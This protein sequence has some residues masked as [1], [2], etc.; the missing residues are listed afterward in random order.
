M[1]ISSEQS[2]ARCGF[3]LH[4]PSAFISSK[5]SCMPG[6]QEHTYYDTEFNFSG[7]KFSWVPHSSTQPTCSERLLHLIQRLPVPAVSHAERGGCCPTSFL[8]AQVS[9]GED[10]FFFPPK[11]F[12]QPAIWSH[13]PQPSSALG[14]RSRGSQRSELDLWIQGFI[15]PTRKDK[16]SPNTTEAT[17]C[18]HIVSYS[19]S[20]KDAA[21]QHLK[22]FPGSNMFGFL[23]MFF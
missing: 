10:R 20:H 11:P 19:H 17:V 8:V 4:V 15:Y 9:K 16:K 22:V 18:R 12:T 3:S 13:V 14:A 2:E 23:N 1:G 5:C 21:C 6:S 7:R